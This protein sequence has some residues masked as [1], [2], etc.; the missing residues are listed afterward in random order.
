MSN[1]AFSAMQI[2][3]S[4]SLFKLGQLVVTRSIHQMMQEGFDVAPF[5]QRHMSG[6]WGDLCE[7]DRLLNTEALTYGDR[8]FSSYNIQW[9]G[10]TKI[11]IIT[12]ADR[13]VTTVLLPSEY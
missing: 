5:I 10:E 12:E 2:L 8:L 4:P 13:S 11:W 6:D 1:H 7:E 9:E 3:F